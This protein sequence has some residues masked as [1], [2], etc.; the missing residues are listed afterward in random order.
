MCSKL[1]LTCSLVVL[2]GVGSAVLIVRCL[3]LGRDASHLARCR[4]QYEGFILLVLCSLEAAPLP[5]ERGKR[6]KNEK[7]YG[8]GQISSFR[9][10]SSPQV[11]NHSLPI[12]TGLDAP[13]DRCMCTDLHR[14]QGSRVQESFHCPVLSQGLPLLKGME[15]TSSKKC[16]AALGLRDLH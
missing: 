4:A 8:G 1:A 3:C 7:K 15:H 2:L 12:H 13:E 11:L 10:K 14:L 9:D 5:G 16:F 6:E